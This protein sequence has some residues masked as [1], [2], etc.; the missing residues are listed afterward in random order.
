MLAG[1]AL[2]AQPGFAA[3]PF[4]NHA[5]NLPTSNITSRI[6]PALPPTGLGPNAT[7]SQNI[8]VASTALAQGKTGLAQ[9]ALENA[10]TLALTRS[11]PAGASTTPD[12]STLVSNLSQARDALGKGDLAGA[13][14]FT[15]LA[16]QEA[17]S[18]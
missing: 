16:M 10:E 7:V 17:G 12:N 18:S 11:V 15:D 5:S 3:N 8:Q 6:A 4:S 2:A 1:L 9:N 14:H 13:K